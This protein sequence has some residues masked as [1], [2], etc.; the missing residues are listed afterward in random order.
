MNTKTINAIQVL[1][2]TLGLA[3][4]LYKFLPATLTPLKMF[5]LVLFVAG[6]ILWVTA[7]LQLGN[8]FSVTAQARALVTHGLYSKIRN[9]IYVSGVLLI[10][11]LA[12]AAG[13]PIYLL[14]LL[15][16]IPLQIQR[17][18]AESKVLEEKFGE[19]YRAYRRQTWF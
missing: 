9:P 17:A 18:G 6:L 12:L 15:V 3:F 7:R 14:A 2:V 19:Q 13:R 1:I 8:S 4:A 11:G 16:I 5:G 10:A